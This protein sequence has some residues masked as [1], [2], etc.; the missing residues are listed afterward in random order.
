MGLREAALVAPSLGFSATRTWRR[1][2]GHFPYASTWC[3]S[4]ANLPQKGIG[5]AL[6]SPHLQPS[7]PPAFASGS[8]L[9]IAWRAAAVRGAS[10]APDGLRLCHSSRPG[11]FHS[12]AQAPA[13]SSVGNRGVLPGR[14]ASVLNLASSE[15][16]KQDLRS[17]AVRVIDPIYPGVAPGGFT[18]ADRACV[19]TLGVPSQ[20]LQL[21]KRKVRDPF[22]RETR[23]ASRKLLFEGSL[24]RNPPG[25]ER[26]CSQPREGRQSSC[27]LPQPAMLRR[28]RSRCALAR[29]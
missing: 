1:L 8:R 14:S 22:G 11:G 19:H 3:K 29:G 4:V 23:S 26:Q 27:A 16:A 7:I 12:A 10:G 18:G 24:F 17:P 15:P 5:S 6:S 21:P 28:H 25:E 2:S 20:T 13:A 9:A